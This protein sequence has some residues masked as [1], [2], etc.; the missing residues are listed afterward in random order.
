[1]T[2]ALAAAAHQAM[3]NQLFELVFVPSSCSL[4]QRQIDQ[5][6]I[7]RLGRHARPGAR[8]AV[9]RRELEDLH[10]GAHHEAN[11][12]ESQKL[13]GA[14]PRPVSEPEMQDLSWRAAV[15]GKNLPSLRR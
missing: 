6:A 8:L 3:P 2:G 1:M 12:Q 15:P 7:G 5:D 11:F 9:D 14:D 4:P 13:S 10:E